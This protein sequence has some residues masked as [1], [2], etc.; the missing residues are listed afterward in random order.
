MLSM[1]SA[2]PLASTVAGIDGKVEPLPL[3]LAKLISNAALLLG[4]QGSG[5]LELLQRELGFCAASSRA[6][7]ARSL[8]VAARSWALAVSRSFVV[9]SLIG[10]VILDGRC[11]GH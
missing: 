3:E 11:P 5:G 2:S 8:A 4:C 7:S 6:T 9:H 10:I 1:V